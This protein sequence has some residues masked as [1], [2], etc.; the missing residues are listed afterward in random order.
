MQQKETGF[1]GCRTK[2]MNNGSENTHLLHNLF[3]KIKSTNTSDH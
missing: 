1:F 3:I 2:Q